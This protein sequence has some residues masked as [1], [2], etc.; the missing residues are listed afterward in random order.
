VKVV[1]VRLGHSSAKT[2]LDTTDTSSTTR[3][4]RLG[5]QSTPSSAHSRPADG[6]RP[7]LV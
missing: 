1:Q 4:T 6:L 5:Q 3:R 7:A 2:T